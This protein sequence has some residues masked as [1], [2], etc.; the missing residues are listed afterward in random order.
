MKAIV[1]EYMLQPNFLS[2]HLTNWPLCL[3]RSGRISFVFFSTAFPTTTAVRVYDT[4]SSNDLSYDMEE[5]TNTFLYQR[6][7]QRNLRVRVCV[8]ETAGILVESSMLKQ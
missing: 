7:I 2:F 4:E 3:S 5:K 1:S 8:C 6:P